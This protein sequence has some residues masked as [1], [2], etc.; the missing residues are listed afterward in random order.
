VIKQ[1]L[2][3]AAIMLALAAPL[4]AAPAGAE[5]PRAEYTRPLTPDNAVVLFIDNQTN[6]MLGV[7]S[8]DTTLLRLNTEGLA[9]L[10]RIYSLP[11]VLTTTGGGGSGP[12]GP[13]SSGITEAFPNAPIIDRIDYFNAMSDPRFAEAVRATGRR[14]IILSGLTTDYCL[15]YPA[16]TLIAQGYHVYFVTDASGSFTAENND[17]ATQR[18]IQMGATPVN[19]Q[20][21]V[22]ELQNSDAVRDLA[23]SKQRLPELLQWFSRYSSTPSILN[24]NM[25]YRAASERR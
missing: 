6:L 9:Q 25:A 14:K 17:A 11:V 20:S 10:A 5:T 4:A 23:A 8:I 18:L 24:M 16:A 21:L 13:L 3:T 19:V 2:S 22:G 7:H 1:A 15:V 12:A